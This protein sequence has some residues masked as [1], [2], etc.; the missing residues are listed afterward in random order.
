M[1]WL[2]FFFSVLFLHGEAAAQ[3]YPAKPIHV[4]TL[5]ANPKLLGGFVRNVEIVTDNKEQ[6]KVVIPVA[7][8]V[9]GP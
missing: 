6:P 8:K 2:G 5:S 1:K 9:V 3:A 4:I 7:A